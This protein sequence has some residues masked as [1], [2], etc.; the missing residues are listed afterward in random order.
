MFHKIKVIA[1][2]LIKISRGYYRMPYL[3]KKIKLEAIWQNISYPKVLLNYINIFGVWGNVSS[4]FLSKKYNQVI[5]II[6]T[7]SPEASIRAGKIR[8]L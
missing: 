6:V 5:S 3:M 8:E 1:P 4:Q 2:E 7:L